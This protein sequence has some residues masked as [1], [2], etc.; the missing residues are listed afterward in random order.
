MKNAIARAIEW[1]GGHEVAVLVGILVPVAGSWAFILLADRVV[2][3][4]TQRIDD[5]IL[6][7]LR[8][9]GDPSRLIGPSGLAE[10]ARDITALGGVTIL[11]LVTT[12]VAGYLLLDRKYRASAFVLAATGGGT[13]VG[14]ALKGVF[15]R[16]RPTVVPHLMPAHHTSFP[17]GHS[18]MSAV[19]YLTL[20]ML[21]IPLMARRRLRFY[22]LMVAI[23]L[24]GLVGA[25]RVLLGVHYPTDVLS[26]WC[27]GIVWACL[28]W[29][30][31]RRLQ[32]RGAV[33]RPAT[34]ETRSP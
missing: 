3:G 29:W 31:E 20:G 23:V 1:I 9:P 33:E 18:M 4:R 25:S 7:A 17:S 26:G 10:S 16:P 2:E 32:R 34:G 6:V 28:C 13:L 14:A 30:V 8:R 22:V 15:D 21:L 27:A 19:V 5:R 12:V 24:T 11:V